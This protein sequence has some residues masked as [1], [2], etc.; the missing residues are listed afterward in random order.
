LSDF[1]P[2]RR[3]EPQIEVTFEID[4]N[5]IMHV[6]AE[7]KAMGI[8]ESI[9]ITND[10]GRLTEEE[11]KRM[12]EEAEQ[13]REE[14]EEM[15]KRVEKRNEL[16]HM[17]YQLKE[18]IDDDDKLG[19]KLSESDKEKVS[20]AVSDAT[21]WMENNKVFFFLCVYLFFFLLNLTDC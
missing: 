11:I 12:Q 4:A 3:G 19:G 9:T 21:E 8:K 18:D 20:D 16:E 13:F 1:P 17:L 14:D 6:T 10:K 15:R 7:E 5:S 2:A